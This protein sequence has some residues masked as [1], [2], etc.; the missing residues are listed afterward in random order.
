MKRIVNRGSF[1]ISIALLCAIP[2]VIAAGVGKWAQ[3]T[4]ALFSY[5]FVF[6]AINHFT[7]P[8]KPVKPPVLNPDG[9][10]KGNYPKAP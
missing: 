2:V 6:S 10:P 9:P 5:A 1:F 3:I 8:P 7:R 4:L